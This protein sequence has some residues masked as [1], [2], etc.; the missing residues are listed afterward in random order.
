MGSIAWRHAVAFVALLLCAGLLPAADRVVVSFERREGFPPAGKSFTGRGVPWGV[1]VKWTNDSA[2]PNIWFTEKGPDG[3]LYSNAPRPVSGDQLAGLG[4]GGSGVNVGTMHLRKEAALGLDSFYWAW[5]GNGDSRPGG[6]AWLEVEYFDL[7]GNSVGKDRFTGGLDPEWNP[8]FEQARPSI[9]GGAL[10]KI[11][12]RGVPPDPEADQH[13]TFFLDDIVLSTRPDPTAPFREV[14][15]EVSRFEKAD[16]TPPVVNLLAPAP[17]TTVDAAAGVGAAFADR[18]TGVDVGSVR[19]LLD[20]QDVTARARVGAGG[21]RFRPPARLAP[22]IHRVE[23]IVSDLAGNRANRAVWRFGVGRPVPV[24]AVFEGGVFKVS[25]EPY[26]PIGIYNASCDPYKREAEARP[27]L[28]QISAAG[29]NCQ[30]VGES[31]GPHELDVMLEYGMKAMKAVS[32]ALE[33]ISEADTTYLRRHAEALR[34]H[35]GLLAWWASDPDTIEAARKNMALGYRTLREADPNHPVIWILSHPVRYEESLAAADA[36]FTYFYPILQ[37]SMT[38]RSIRE[39]VLDKAF[40]VA[41]RQG[42]QVWFASQE[43]DLRICDGKKLASRDDFRPT[44][45]EMRAMNYLALI[46]GVKGLFFYAAGGSQTPGVYND[47][48]EY[49]PQWNELLRISSEVRHIAPFLMLGE[50][51]RTA[52]TENPAIAYR[53]LEMNGVHLLIALNLADA[54]TTAKWSFA[55]PVRPSVLFEDRVLSAEQDTMADR[56]GPLEVHIYRWE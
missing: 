51:V 34:D 29:V 46:E 36:C 7:N 27:Y 9:Q 19:I 1:V 16:T 53:E 43:I 20:G 23:V 39:H 56:F 40:E 12:F 54:P 3:V 44:P 18:G 26:F 31:T 30:M 10:S 11:V 41:D 47:L 5:R 55:R 17:D 14:T 45:A 13:G 25:E 32:W 42:K 4:Q 35:P 48:T 28:A 21:F 6:N 37:G 52:A 24:K 8:K 50:P 15:V 33:H 22:G 2:A 49:P 38:V